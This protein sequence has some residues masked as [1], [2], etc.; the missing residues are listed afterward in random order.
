[1]SGGGLHPHAAAETDFG[2]TK[3]LKIIARVANVEMENK[4][5]KKVFMNIHL[6]ISDSPNVVNHQKLLLLMFG[7][8][9]LDKSAFTSTEL[10]E[11][12]RASLKKATAR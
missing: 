1:M 9:R 6:N 10:T 12:S 4:D 5:F 7:K 8:I 3:I 11:R 2:F